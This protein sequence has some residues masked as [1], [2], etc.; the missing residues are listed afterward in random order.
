MYCQRHTQIWLSFEGSQF[1]VAFMQFLYY[2]GFIVGP[3]SVPPER[4][5][6]LGHSMIGHQGLMVL[7]GMKME[8]CC[9]ECALEDEGRKEQLQYIAVVSSIYEPVWLRFMLLL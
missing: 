7:I 2:Q 5:V 1:S 3:C 8:T 6:L 9:F 4:N